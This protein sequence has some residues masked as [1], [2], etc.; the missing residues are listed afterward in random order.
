MPKPKEFLGGVGGAV[1]HIA[2]C[3]LDKEMVRRMQ[4]RIL[5]RSDHQG[6]FLLHGPVALRDA[7]FFDTGSDDTVFTESLALLLGLD[8]QVSG[9]FN[10][11]AKNRNLCGPQGSR[12]L[13]STGC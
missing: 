2:V 5:G 6:G 11:R 7:L 8:L 3:R 12:H 1:Q 10:A 9:T 4:A 13:F